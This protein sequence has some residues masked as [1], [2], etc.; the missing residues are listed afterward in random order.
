MVGAELFSVFLSFLGVSNKRCGVVDT[1]TV[2]RGC[3]YLVSYEE[4]PCWQHERL[5]VG[6]VDDGEWVVLMPCEDLC[7]DVRRHRRP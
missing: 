6:L 5:I 7:S 2:E 4:G 1:V 3:R